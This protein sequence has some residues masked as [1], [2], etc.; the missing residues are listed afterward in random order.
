MTLDAQLDRKL[1]Y[2]DYVLIPDDG[3]RHELVDGVH[4]VNPA[5]STYHQLVAVALVSQLFL[6]VAQPGLGHV[7]IAPTDVELSP[8]DVV[9][10]DLV[11][12]SA[13]R[14]SIVLPTHIRGAPD[15]LIE[16]VSPSSARLDRVLKKE[17]YAR[18]GVPEYWIIDPAQRVVER[19]ILRAGEYELQPVASRVALAH[20]PG[21]EIDLSLIW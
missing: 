14:A 8:H 2:D 11:V 7:L 18:A 5:P 13:A 6:R 20:L 1:T 9:Q 16:I 19:Y 21:V 10:P 12:V 17:R 15:L 3:Q 4:L